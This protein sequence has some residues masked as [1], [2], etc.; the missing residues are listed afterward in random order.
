MVSRLPS[1][2]FKSHKRSSKGPF[3]I[4]IHNSQLGTRSFCLCVRLLETS[5]SK[6]ASNTIHLG[7]S[8]N[9][10]L[11]WQLYLLTALVTK[12]LSLCCSCSSTGLYLQLTANF[13]KPNNVSKPAY[14]VNHLLKRVSVVNIKF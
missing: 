7:Q 10:N 4:M 1:Q 5:L 3:K 6:A 14:I 13:Y 9:C 11:L 8:Y 12:T 2:I